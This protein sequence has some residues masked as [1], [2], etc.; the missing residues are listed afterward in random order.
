MKQ[1]NKF[2]QGFIKRHPDGFGFFIPDDHEHADVY[3]P[4]HSMENIMTND[5][6]MV[7][8]F[9]EKGGDRFHGEILR[10]L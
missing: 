8:V 7:Q 1:K 9:A 3:I 6:V 2:L 5:R 4:K 10:I